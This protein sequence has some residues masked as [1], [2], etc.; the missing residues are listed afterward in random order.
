M[1]LFFG[2]VGAFATF[3]NMCFQQ[4]S[5]RDRLEFCLDYLKETLEEEEKKDWTWIL[6]PSVTNK[7]LDISIV[8]D[9]SDIID[10]TE[11]CPDIREWVLQR[12]IS[13]PLLVNGHKFH[14]RVYVLCLGALKVYV[15]GGSGILMLLAAHKYSSDTEDSFA[16]LSN[17]A[18]GAELSDFDEEKYVMLLDDLPQCLFRDYPQKFDSLNSA[19]VQVEKIRSS[20]NSITCELFR[21]YE[22]EYTVFSPMANCFEL[23]GLDFMMDENFNVSLLEVFM[24][25]IRDF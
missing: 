17:T 7:G 22:N 20:I 23:Y 1:Q 24:M 3:D 10:A 19:T 18:K 13:N 9:F 21:A 12:Y 2:G 11:D 6:K 16:H 5:L 8:K 4:Q 15:Y 25:L 14:L